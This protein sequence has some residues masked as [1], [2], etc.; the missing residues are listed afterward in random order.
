MLLAIRQPGP[1]PNSPPSWLSTPN[2][3]T[4]AGVGGVYQLA[5]H[6]HDVDGDSVSFALNALSAALPTGWSIVGTTLVDDGSGTAGVTSGVILDA[7]DGVNDP[8]NSS[9]FSIT[10]NAAGSAASFP[11]FDVYSAIV[12]AR[13][14]VPVPQG[15][16]HYWSAKPTIPASG[17]VYTS[18]AALNTAIASAS[19]GDVLKLQD[20]TYNDAA[21][22]IGPNGTAANRITVCSETVGGVRFTGDSTITVDGDHVTLLGFDFTNTVNDNV[23]IVTFNGDNGLA[24]LF[25][26]DAIGR[27]NPDNVLVCFWLPNVTPNPTRLRVCYNEFTNL[28]ARVKPFR[29]QNTNNQYV[30]FDHNDVIDLLGSNDDYEVFQSGGDGAAFN[31]FCLI[32]NNYILRFNNNGGVQSTSESEIVANK[33]SLNTYIRNVLVDCLGHLNDRTA[34]RTTYYANFMFGTNLT[35]AGGIW[36]GGD[37][38]WV[39]CNYIAEME[40]RALWFRNGGDGSYIASN[41]GEASF[42]TIH[43]CRES[44]E[45]GTGATGPNNPDGNALYNN[46][47]LKLPAATA[48]ITGTNETNTTFAGNVMSTPV[49]LTMGAGNTAAAPELEDDNGYMVPTAAGNCDQTGA[50]GWSSLCTVDILGNPIPTSN[51]NV[52]C[53]QPGWDLTTDPIA[54]IIAAAGR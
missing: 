8:V 24:A 1:P 21:I 47:V 51:P 12:T 50:A 27:T 35:D 44:I 29:S 45:F 43:N 3:E 9:P 23:S 16:L 25:K 19:P 28:T 13:G 37:E 11:L 39:F 5:Q 20:G 41:D 34:H 22:T 18:V 36:T 49:G 31:A 14:G 4:T 52:G 30:R 46:A 32:D 48:S 33:S 38:P 6:T 42:N 26:F 54:A 53:F 17:T 40:E 7:D 10:I 2:P 15:V